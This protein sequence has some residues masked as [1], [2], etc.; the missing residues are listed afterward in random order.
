VKIPPNKQ[1]IAD[2]L[3]ILKNR[4]LRSE[5]ELIWMQWAEARLQQLKTST[6][7][8]LDSLI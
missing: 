5:A 6:T 3:D 2:T 8:S 4:Y 1:W 7:V